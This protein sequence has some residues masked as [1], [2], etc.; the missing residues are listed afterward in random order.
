MVFHSNYGGVILSDSTGDY[1]MEVYGVS[2]GSGGPVSF[3]GL[4]SYPCE[5]GPTAEDAETSMYERW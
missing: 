2:I 5:V 3:F 1:A 4:Y